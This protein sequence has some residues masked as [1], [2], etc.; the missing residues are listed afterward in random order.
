MRSRS[1][2]GFAPGPYSG[3][4]GGVEAALEKSGYGPAAT[5]HCWAHNANEQVTKSAK[6]QYYRVVSYYENCRK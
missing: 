5:F 1:R 6:T 2:T 3:L 4:D